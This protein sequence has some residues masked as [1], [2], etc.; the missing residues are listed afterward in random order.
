MDGMGGWDKER[1]TE[2]GGPGRGVYTR[3]ERGLQ[4]R[5]SGASKPDAA[6]SFE[7]EKE[8]RVGE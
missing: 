5:V 2:P 7:N 3:R 8:E 4:K 6:D 1:R